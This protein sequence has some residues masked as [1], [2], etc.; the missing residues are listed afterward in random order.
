MPEAG[1]SL[2]V[3]AHVD[4]IPRFAAEGAVLLRQFAEQARNDAGAVRYEVLQE[5]SRPNHFTVVAVWSSRDAFDRHTAADHT[6]RFREQLHPMLGSPFD[7][8]LH[9]M[10][11]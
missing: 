9:Q 6:R 4:V 7:E 2:Y 5:S 10:L 1:D 8:R 11:P 3:V